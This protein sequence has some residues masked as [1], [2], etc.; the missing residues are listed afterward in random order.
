MTNEIKYSK[1]KHRS[2]AK[3]IGFAALIA[4]GLLIITFIVIYA[5]GYRYMKADTENGYIKFFGKVNGSGTPVSGT[6]YYSDGTKGEI[7]FRE[8]KVTYS[9]GTVYEGTL[10]ALQRNGNGT[11][12]YP[13][14]DVYRGAFVNAKITGKGEYVFANGDT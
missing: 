13:N 3:T 9:D 2:P 1:K 12:T 14:G 7:D 11:L 10:T 8:S 4:V 5:M 6:L